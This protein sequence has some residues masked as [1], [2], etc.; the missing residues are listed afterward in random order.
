[1]GSLIGIYPYFCDKCKNRF[2]RSRPSRM[3]F[4]VDR[5]TSCPNCSFTEVNPVNK[6]RVPRSWA[7]YWCRIVGIPS[8]RCPECRTKYFSVRPRKKTLQAKS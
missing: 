5:W 2:H 1:M 3:Q 6:D 4:R 7:N 8:Y